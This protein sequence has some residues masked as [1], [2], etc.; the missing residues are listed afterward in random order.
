[1]R[2]KRK[3]HIL[4][5]W[6]H[7]LKLTLLSLFL[8]CGGLGLTWIANLKVPDL[9]SFEDRRVSES[10]K[11]YDRTGEILLYDVFANTKRVLI[12]SADISRNI[13]NATVAIEDDAFYGHRG[14][15][16]TSILRAVLANLISTS[17][18][19]GG[20]TITQ[21]VVK[22]SILTTEKTISRKLKEWVL[23][24]KLEK[25]FSKD[26][27]LSFYL[28]EAPYGG[29]IYGIEE[30]SRMFFNTNASNLSLAQAAYLAAMPQA[31]TFYSPYG[32]HREDLDKRKN[33]VLD[34]MLQNKFITEDEYAIGKAETVVF[35]PRSETGIKA[36][37]FALYIREQLEQM[38]GRRGLEMG[39]FKVITSL[40]YGLQAKAEEIT[41]RFAVSNEKTFNAENAAL[42]AI[43]PKTG[44]VLVM[45]G[46]RDYF[47]PEI[48]GNFNV[49]LAHRQPGSAFK[50]FVYATAFMKGY[51]PETVVFDLPTEFQTTCNPDGTPIIAGREAECYMPSNYD[52][53]FRGPVSLRQALSQSLNIPAIKTLYLAGIRDSLKVAKDMGIKGL[54]NSDQYGLTLVLGGGEVSLFEITSGYGVFA[55]QGIR[56]EPI[57]ILRIEDQNGKI[58]K[59]FSS[60]AF[61]VIPDQV[62]LQ[63]SDILSDKTDGE[64]PYI[65]FGNREVAAKTGTTNDYRDAWVI[66]YTPNIAVGAWAG[67]NDNTPM[68]KKVAGF[69]ITPLWKAFMEE[70]LPLI[71]EENF[72]AYT[73]IDKNLKPILRGFWQGN[74]TYFLDRL[75]GKLATEFTP[76]ELKEEKSISNI[77]SI[78]YWID[79]SNP[80]GLAP[81]NPANDSQFLHWEEPVENWLIQNGLAGVQPIIPTGFDD[82][83]KPEFFPSVT[84]LSPQA[85]SALSVNS[86]VTASLRTSGHFAVTRADYFL[87]G[88]FIGSSNR[89]PFGLSFVLSDFPTSTGENTLR[90]VVY[91]AVLNR[92]EASLTF[93]SL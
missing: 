35:S 7:P 81:T 14:I 92:G 44:E 75:S 37:H 11:I 61:Q 65:N 55:N 79:R 64:R 17:Y 10:T 45:V 84:I 91:D 27:I 53:K 47:D 66:G 13:K 26:E 22:N 40:D 78:L 87:N 20:S 12:S 48:D 82:I 71:P 23:A 54:G 69:I 46:S 72:P 1:M 9:G 21:Q 76:Q 68:E 36:P 56:H 93:R 24:L 58:L 80:A 16:P 6:H 5:F 28:N 43:D 8:V 59:E 30:A 73:P 32:S 42:V 2:K 85:N 49:T 88:S 63:I 77:H 38:Y 83:H 34:K 25:Q 19:Q 41:K 15:K 31:P 52:G 50:P 62:A 29:N 39:G 74:E 67:N 33:L 18:G 60:S 3:S 86:Q 51:T 4:S 70:V 90:V 57:S 89:Y